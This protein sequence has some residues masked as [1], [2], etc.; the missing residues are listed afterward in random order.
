MVLVM[1]MGS[2]MASSLF[3][4]AFQQCWRFSGSSESYPVLAGANLLLVRSNA[5][6]TRDMATGQQIAHVKTPVAPE[7]AAIYANDMVVFTGT[8]GSL[9]ALNAATGQ[10]VWEQRSVSGRPSAPVLSGNGVYCATGEPNPGIWGFDLVNGSPLL[11]LPLSD[12][13]LAAPL[14]SGRFLIYGTL[15]GQVCRV[16]LASGNIEDTLVPS[17]GGA[18][19]G[20]SIAVAGANVLLAPSGYANRVSCIRAEPGLFKAVSSAWSRTF[21]NQIDYDLEQLQ[22]TVNLR[23][24]VRN[25][26][27]RKILGKSA[28]FKGVSNFNTAFIPLGETYM[29]GWTMDQGSAAIVVR[30]TGLDARA[31]Y[32]ILVVHAATGKTLCEYV[33]IC[34]DTPYMFNADPVFTASGVIA[35]IGKGLL[36]KIDRETGELENETMLGDYVTVPLVAAKDR[37]VVQ[38]IKGTVIAFSYGDKSVDSPLEYAIGQN[39]PNPFNPF[40][41]IQYQV[42]KE[43]RVMLKVFDVR[44]REIVTL[45]N[46][47]REAGRYSV[48]WDGTAADK[49]QV[50]SGLYFAVFEAGKYKKIVKMTMLK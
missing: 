22:E 18:F 48:Q 5:F 36:V 34:D 38:T 9:F 12:P 33:R 50:T 37:F 30:E 31:K 46:E 40:T 43:S 6:E 2:F 1:V 44:G 20:K 26:A 7:G 49:K 29:S 25:Q 35:C 41:T 39:V 28:L 16:S 19:L 4:S 21:A 17:V 15:R 14:V 8:A 47:A 10:I 11:M 32:R 27:F 23:P 24:N 42:P 45:V 3:G 13:V